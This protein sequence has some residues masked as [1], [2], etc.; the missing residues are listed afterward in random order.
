MS[1]IEFNNFEIENNVKIYLNDL[2]NQLNNIK[3]K[4]SN[5]VVPYNF[6]Y[7]TYLNNLDYNIESNLQNLN[8]IENWINR[9][10]NRIKS[11][12]N[13]FLKQVNNIEITKIQNKIGSINSGG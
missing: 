8:N 9:S 7:K 2:Q 12:S 4:C 1:K 10:I 3:I 5:L 11:D 6:R 13:E